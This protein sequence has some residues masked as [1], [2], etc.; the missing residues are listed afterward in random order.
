[1][2]HEAQHDRVGQFL[3]AGAV[4]GEVECGEGVAQRRHAL[5]GGPAPLGGERHAPADQR[6]AQ[7]DQR[8]QPRFEPALRM[9][10]TAQPQRARQRIERTEPR[11][12][13]L[14]QQRRAGVR[15][16]ASGSCSTGSG[17][18]SQIRG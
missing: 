4:G 17:G 11:F 9:R 3:P 7:R 6:L 1:M 5:R 13:R 10:E 2:E 16:H 8:G 15:R 14:E 12:V 18:T